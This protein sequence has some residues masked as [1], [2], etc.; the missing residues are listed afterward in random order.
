MSNLRLSLNKELCLQANMSHHEECFV[1]TLCKCTA[2]CLKSL[3]YLDVSSL[4]MRKQRIGV[5]A[6]IALCV[7]T[8]IN[9]HWLI[10]FRYR[11][12]K[13]GFFNLKHP[14]GAE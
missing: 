5:A 4:E 6:S 8:L 2:C 13:A 10:D 3:E 11:G 9:R 1:S 14:I 12:K 7:Q